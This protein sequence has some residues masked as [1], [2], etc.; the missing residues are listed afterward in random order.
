MLQ[1]LSLYFSHPY[2]ARLLCSMNLQS[3]HGCFKIEQRQWNRS[4]KSNLWEAIVTELQCAERQTNPISAF[5]H[6]QISLE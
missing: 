1:R 4:P 5:D 2:N 6:L 3:T